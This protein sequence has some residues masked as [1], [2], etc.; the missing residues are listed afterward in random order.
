MITKVIFINGYFHSIYR[1][2]C[3]FVSLFS[4]LQTD[5]QIFSDVSDRFSGVLNR[6]TGRITGVLNRVT[7]R[8]TG[9]LNSYR[10]FK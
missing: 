1:L 7:G 4:Y 5:L 8:I 3:I 9:V 10:C 6:V 2:F